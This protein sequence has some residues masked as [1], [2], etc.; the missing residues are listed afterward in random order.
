MTVTVEFIDGWGDTPPEFA[1]VP[2]KSLLP[3][4][5]KKTT[6]HVHNNKHIYD[7]GKTSATVKKCIPVFDALTSGYLIRLVS[8]VE[9]GDSMSGKK[10]YRWPGKEMISFHGPMQLGEFPLKEFYDEQV[11]KF[12]NPWGIKT[13]KGYSCLFI[14]PMNRGESVLRIFEG[15][16][17]TDTYHQPVQLPFLLNDHSWSGVI[18]AGTPIAQVIPFKR[19]SFDH[20][21]KRDDDYPDKPAYKTHRL[22]RSIFFDAYKKMF[23]SRKEYN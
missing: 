11:P 19:E 18:P 9:I 5:Y 21:I 14:N 17:D 1:P 7:D 6:A 10:F 8:D 22:R 4:W 15:V 16:V 13:P 12:H 20:T 2:A 3:E 23:W